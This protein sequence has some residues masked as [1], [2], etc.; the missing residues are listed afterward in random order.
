MEETVPLGPPPPVT[1]GRLLDFT[2]DPIAC[3]RRLRA[4]HGNLAVLREGAQKIVF[5]FGPELNQRVLSDAATFHSRFFTIRGSRRSSQRRLT[6]GLMSMNG[7]EHKTHRRIVMEPFQKKSLGR[8]HESIC[9]LT[10]ALLD[11]WRPGDVLDMHREMTRHMLR[12]TSELLFGVDIPEFACRVGAMLDRWV[13]LNHE[14]GM[15]AFISDPALCERY[16]R[17]LHLAAQLERDI[18]EMIELRRAT[19]GSTDV[20]SLLIDAHDQEGRVDDGQIIGHVALL[21]GA[22][23]LTTAHTLTWTLFLLAQHPSVMRALDDEIGANVAGAAPTPEETSRM[24]LTERVLKESMRVLPASSYSPRVTAV[25]TRLGPLQ[26]APE[27]PVIFSQFITH[28]LPE[29]YDDPDSFRPE[30][31][32]RIAPSPY[33]YLPFGAGPRMCL[34]APL[35]MMTLRTILPAILKRYRLSVVPGAEI[36]GRVIATMLGPVTRVPMRVWPADGLFQSVPVG[37][38]IHTLVHL[39]EA[40]AAAERRAA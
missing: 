14:A 3:M 21:F 40:P 7:D 20:L 16:D 31:W 5:V 37:G 38:N 35:A 36:S 22:A 25:P 11:A 6:S 32:L 10:Q 30:R 19:A 8:Y 15:G 13:Q 27:T 12:V 2:D 34:G 4:A 33:A 29:L 9:N 17:L 24:P 23:H 1:H 28:H 26:L 18:R 39:R